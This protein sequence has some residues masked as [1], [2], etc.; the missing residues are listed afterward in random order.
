MYLFDNGVD[1]VL[2]AHKYYSPRSNILEIAFILIR[3]L[4]LPQWSMPVV[5]HPSSHMVVSGSFD[6]TLKLWDKTTGEL[7]H[8]DIAHTDAIEEVAVSPTGKLL[9]AGSWDNR[10]SVWDL[11][12]HT[13]NSY[14]VEPYG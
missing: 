4:K 2:T 10:I 12:T 9:V 6:G 1:S 11:D 7:L 3:R 8:S 13:A 14:P 5:T